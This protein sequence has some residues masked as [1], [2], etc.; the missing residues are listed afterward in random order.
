MSNGRYGVRALCVAHLPCVP[1]SRLEQCLG[2]NKEDLV[3]AA[4]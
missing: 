4:T 1:D 3:I 2:G